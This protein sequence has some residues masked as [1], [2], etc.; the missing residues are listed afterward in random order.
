MLEI[1]K[2]K[3]DTTN[4]QEKLNNLDL[5]IYDLFLKENKNNNIDKK[6]AKKV[7]KELKQFA[8]SNN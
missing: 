4:E 7:V 6:K 8:N 1:L 2:P 5:I 3:K